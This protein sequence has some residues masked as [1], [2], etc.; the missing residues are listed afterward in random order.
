MPIASRL[1]RFVFALALS[2][3]STLSPA[4]TPNIPITAA[5]SKATL[6]FDFET[7]NCDGGT[8]SNLG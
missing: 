3:L 8:P 6:L 7:G 5:P 4:Q 2:L 1:F